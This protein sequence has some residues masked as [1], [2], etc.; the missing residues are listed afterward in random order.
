M[1]FSKEMAQQALEATGGSSVEAAMDW[2][3]S[4]PDDE[5]FKIGVIKSDSQI[6]NNDSIQSKAIETTP[7]E[8]ESKED[9]P[10]EDQLKE[11]Q[12]KEDQP[13]EDQSNQLIIH[14]AIC[15]SCMEKIVGIRWKCAVCS[16]YDLCTNC[17]D[18]RTH[19]VEHKFEAHEKD[20]ENPEKNTFDKRRTSRA[21]AK[22]A[23]KD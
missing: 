6:S 22:I 3:F 12:L 1:G 10:K 7:M 20:I 21:K 15:N 9:Q 14:N 23:R 2:C 13:K 11:D 17:Y 19:S 16:D 5:G 18:K 8:V 4:Q